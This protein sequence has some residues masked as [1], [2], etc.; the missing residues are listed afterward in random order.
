[1]GT[2]RRVAVMLGEVRPGS[3][4]TAGFGCSGRG[5]ALRGQ[6]GRGSQG[7]ASSGTVRSGAFWRGSHGL[8]RLVMA[9]LVKI[10]LGEAV[11]VLRGM[12]RLSEER[13]GRVRQSGLGTSR[14]GAVC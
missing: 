8:L 10:R 13:L 4:G 12:S 5:E 1:M 11:K 14:R 7:D 9:S 3:H 2:V 6:S